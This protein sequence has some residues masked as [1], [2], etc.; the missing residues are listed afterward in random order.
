MRARVIVLAGPSGSGKSRLSRRLGLPV[1]NLDDFYKDGSDPSLPRL[2]M[3]LVDWDHPDSWLRE[4]ALDAIEALCREGSSAV[5][6]YN[7]AHDG[8]T[9]HQTL[10]LDGSGFFV[11]EGIFAHEVV[12]LCAGRDLLADAICVRHHR[13]VTFWRRLTRDLKERRKPPHVLVR[14]GLML[15]RAEPAVVARAVARGCAAMTPEQ[16]YR[17]VRALTGSA[18]RPGTPR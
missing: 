14:R 1:L 5:P 13:V 17:R 11:A 2:E 15:L 16:A 4:E 12:E 8:R 9:G 6:V 10:S 7:I 3:G 18:A